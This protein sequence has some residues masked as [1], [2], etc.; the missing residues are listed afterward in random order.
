MKEKPCLPELE[1]K[2]ASFG[3]LAASINKDWIGAS[4]AKLEQIGE[5]QESLYHTIWCEEDKKYLE[6]RQK[7]QTGELKFDESD[8]R[9]L[10]WELCQE[11]R[12]YG[13]IHEGFLS[14][15]RKSNAIGTLPEELVELRHRTNSLQ[16]RNDLE[17]PVYLALEQVTHVIGNYG[18]LDEFYLEDLEK[19]IIETK[20]LDILHLPTGIHNQ[21]SKLKW[22]HDI[23]GRLFEELSLESCDVVVNPSDL[24]LVF[25]NLIGN[26]AKYSGEKLD[27]LDLFTWIGISEDE[28]VRII[29][30]DNGTGFDPKMLEQVDGKVRAL[31]KGETTKG[32]G[33]GLWLVDNIISEMGGQVSL[34]NAKDLGITDL[35][36]VTVIDFPIKTQF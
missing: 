19:L 23:R 21:I 30:A 6:L 26:S 15:E 12:K 24:Y 36:A 14:W 5:T 10:V 13:A 20:K 22:D 9:K 3:H 34:L 8:P 25:D 33:L 18:T 4:E 29:Y 27:N 2:Q 16:T 11:Y 17:Y 28:K 35:G 1:Q 32:T 7:Y 31:K